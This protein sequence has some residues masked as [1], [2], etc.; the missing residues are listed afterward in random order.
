MTTRK[1]PPD[2]DDFSLLCSSNIR[3]C[4]H[5]I[6][7]R[8]DSPIKD[9]QYVEKIVADMS[10]QS[11]GNRMYTVHSSHP[12]ADPS[13]KRFIVLAVYVYPRYLTSWEKYQ[14]DGL[15]IH[16]VRRV[17]LNNLEAAISWLHQQ[18]YVR[19]SVID[20]LEPK[21]IP[22]IRITQSMLPAR[23][24]SNSIPPNNEEQ[25]IPLSASTQGILIFSF[26]IY[27]VRKD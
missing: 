3:S 11:K 18:G 27:L 10:V 7:F 5:L 4:A 26:S 9:A 21:K 13:I 22:P 24:N 2:P 20:A 14:F 17:P 25:A 15:T 19:K 12:T 16:Q 23:T 6:L 8:E 1:L